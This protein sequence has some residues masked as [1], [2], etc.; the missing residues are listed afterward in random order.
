MWQ[1]RRI[2]GLAERISVVDPITGA[3]IASQ[4]V[5]AFKNGEYVTFNLS[6]YVQ[7]HNNRGWRGPLPC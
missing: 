4:D 1:R 5:T 6:G 2:S 3:L 7:V